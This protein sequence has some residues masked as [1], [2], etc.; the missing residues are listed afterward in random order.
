M[1]DLERAEKVF[2][3]YSNNYDRNNLMMERKIEHTYRVKDNSNIIAKALNLSGEEIELA[4]LIGLLH[5]I[6]R[7]EH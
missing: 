4:T 2:E 5:D 7:F 3:D 6:G 1:I